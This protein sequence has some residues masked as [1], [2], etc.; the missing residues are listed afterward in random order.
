MKRL[1]R[2]VAGGHAATLVII[3]S[4]N[5]AHAASDQ[6]WYLR[7][8]RIAEAQSV[9]QGEGVTV[10]VID[11]GVDASHPDL[12]GGVLPGTDMLDPAVS[13]DG[14]VD[15]DGHGTRMAGLIAGRGRLLGIAPKAKILPIRAIPLETAPDLIAPAVDWAIDHGATVINLSAGGPI[16]NLYDE[17]AIERAVA[18]DI[19]VVAGAGNGAGGPIQYP[20]GY[21]GVVA[22]TGVDRQGRHAAISSVGF[23]AVVAAP[24]VDIYSTTLH[25]GY[26]TATGTSDATAI[27]SGIIALIRSKYPSLSAEEVLHRLTATADDRGPPGRD[28]VYGYGIVDPVKALTADVPLL[29][30]TPVITASNGT[31]AADVSAR[32]N[33]VVVVGLG[34]LVVVVLVAAGVI[35]GRRAN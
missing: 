30:P 23:Q 15:S 2:L 14:R 24:A 26:S 3:S 28:D 1:A 13:V 5:P 22:V 25:H 17:Q 7:F 19:V 27:V 10:A 18:A 33:P 34:L 11:S 16:S 31:A 8:L 32:L 4:S 9:S 21:A 12:Q 29:T 20:A 35:V 6:Q